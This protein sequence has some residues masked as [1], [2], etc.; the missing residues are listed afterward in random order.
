VD[1]VN[2]FLRDQISGAPVVDERGVCMGVLSASDIVKLEDKRATTAP[3]Q[4]P[5]PQSQCPRFDTWNAGAQWWLDAQRIGKELQ[6]ILEQ[7]VTGYMTRDVVS[8]TEDTPIGVVIRSM[9]DAHLH[10]VIV[11]DSARRPVGIVSTIDILA[12]ALR[13]GR[14]E[15]VPSYA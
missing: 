15:A 4:Q 2:V 13:A 6:P 5:G 14:R 3:D 11:L 12:A 7:S 10:R 1:A 9:V 8:V